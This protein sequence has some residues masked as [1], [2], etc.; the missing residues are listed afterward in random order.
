MT[1]EN[2]APSGTAPSLYYARRPEGQ[3]G[4][5][6]QP[7]KGSGGGAGRARRRPR[8]GAR[9]PDSPRR[10]ETRAFRLQLRP[11][12]APGPAGP[13]LSRHATDAAAKTTPKVAK[14]ASRAIVSSGPSRRLRSPDS[15]G[16]PAHPTPTSGSCRRAA[17]TRKC[18]SDS[19]GFFRAVSSP[20]LDVSNPSGART[21]PIMPLAGGNL[22]CV[23]LPR[24]HL[25]RRKKSQA[26]SYLLEHLLLPPIFGMTSSVTLSAPDCAPY[27]LSLPPVHHQETR[28][29]EETRSGSC[30]PGEAT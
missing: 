20:P 18:N 2:G 29:L 19:F 24:G 6:G 11:L 12:R 15:A 9:G 28:S 13:S 7:R 23:S 8:G 27:Q 4:P 21:E 30:E 16:T 17:A 10:P 22:R 14:E 3:V 25:C 5:R 1:P 26:L